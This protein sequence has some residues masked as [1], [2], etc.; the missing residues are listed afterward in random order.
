M[1]RQAF[2]VK[3]QERGRGEAAATSSC[4][5]RW[6]VETPHG[7]AS[8]GVCAFCHVERLFPNYIEDPYP[9]SDWVREVAGLGEG[10]REIPRPIDEGA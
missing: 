8:K 7:P 4:R 6:V 2:A 10:A 5:H 9:R 1:K 3:P